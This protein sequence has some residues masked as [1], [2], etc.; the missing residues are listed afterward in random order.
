MK[1]GKCG[2]VFCSC[3]AVGLFWK[4]LA[5]AGAFEYRLPDQRTAPVTWNSVVGFMQAHTVR[6]NETL[7]DIARI[8]G[9]GFNEIQLLYPRTDP[10]IPEVGSVVSIPT[11]WVLPPTRHEGIVINIPE[12]RLYRFFPK[13][14]AVKTYPIGIGDRATQTPM[15]VCRVADRQ[16]YPVWVIPDSLRDKYPV[17]MIPPGPENPLG[18][19]WLGLSRQGY[20]IHGTNFAWC[21][22]R[23]VSNGCIRLYPEHIEQLFEETPVGT[24]V[25]IIY[26]P[27]KVGFRGEEV[28]VEVHP[29]LYQKIPR[30]EEYA[31]QRLQES[32]SLRCIS[33]E[34][35]RTALEQCTGAPVPVGS[36]KEFEGSENPLVWSNG[37][38]LSAGK[39]IN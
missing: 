10:W 4:S 13:I 27:V 24:S 6:E 21:V 22:G 18:K 3:L 8:Y 38:V 7:L 30:M 16:I 29:D 36:L 25:E 20:G 37:G 15:G 26:E 32:V 28:F 19:Y 12:M 33:M 17:S 34:S 23:S 5:F 31:L 9:L 1:L 14:H 35:L 39:A 2:Q 11:H